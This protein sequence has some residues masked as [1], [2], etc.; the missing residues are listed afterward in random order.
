V[1]GPRRPGSVDARRADAR[2]RRAPL[3]RRLIR[4]AL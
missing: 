2:R 3:P 1:A 4:P